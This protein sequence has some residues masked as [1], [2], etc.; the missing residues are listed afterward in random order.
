MKTE[1]ILIL[2]MVFLVLFSGFEASSAEDSLVSATDFSLI[3]F[4][5]KKFTLS[6]ELKNSKAILLWFTN[7]CKGCLKK[8]SEM[9]KMKDLYK[10]KGIEVVAI[11]ILGEDRKT[12][13]EVIRRKALTFR[14]LFDPEGEVTRLFSGEYFPGTCSLKN[15]FIIDKNKKILFEGRYPGI[16]EEEIEYFLNRL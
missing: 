2:V 7:L 3:D 6:D 11:S 14:F 13:E 15:L 5:G 12:V 9:E 1:T 4:H 16:E 10:E 8:I